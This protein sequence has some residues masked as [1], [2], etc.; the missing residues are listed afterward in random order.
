MGSKKTK[1]QDK[2]LIEL[3]KGSFI[4]LIFKA[5]G[6]VLGVVFTWIVAQYYGAEGVGVYIAFWSILMI[7]SVLAKLGFDTAIVKFIAAF[8]VKRQFEFI[9]RIYKKVILWV[10]ISSCFLALIVI[11][12]SK[13]L[14]IL[15]FDSESYQNLMILLGILVFPFSVIAINAEAMKG[16]KKITAFSFFQNASILLLAILFIVIISIYRIEKTDVLYAIAFSIVVLLPL[17][18]IVWK[19]LLTRKKEVFNTKKNEK[20]PFTN[21]Q[22]FKISIPMLLGNSL[23]LLMNWTDA[24]MLGAMR[25]LTELGVYNTALKIAALSSAVLVAVN[26]IAMPKYAELYEEKNKE[27]MKRFVKQT[28]LLIFFLTAPIVLV[29]FLFPKELLMFFGEEFVE[30]K[31]ALLML[32]FAQFFSAISGSTIHLL[33]MSGSEKIAQNIL[34]FSAALNL[35]LNYLLIPLYGIMGAAIA[36]ASVT[37]LWNILAVVFIYKKLGFLTYPVN[38]KIEKNE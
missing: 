24:L 16:L 28:T 36:T 31:I 18:L 9:R 22:I 20:F 27:R 8:S 37:V 35:L 23:F 1:L 38:L 25:N 21:K 34:L 4:A 12:L 3:L 32:C 14:A 10:F 33:N 19:K 29:T 5:I 26:S 6:I 7:V 17:S 2:N 30:G 11:V 13:S 15:F